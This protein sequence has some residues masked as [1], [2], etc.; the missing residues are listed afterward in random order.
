MDD[1]GSDK[2]GEDSYD[3]EPDKPSQLHVPWENLRTEPSNAPH[4]SEAH[5]FLSAAHSLVCKL[6][7]SAMPFHI[8]STPKIRGAVGI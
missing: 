6:H 1:D 3:E 5:F 7:D 4:Y 8:P 2:E